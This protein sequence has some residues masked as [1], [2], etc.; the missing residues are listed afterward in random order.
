MASQVI[1]PDSSWLLLNSSNLCKCSICYLQVMF[2]H[3]SLHLLPLVPVTPSP[4]LVLLQGTGMGSPAG[5]WVEAV[6]VTCYMI[7]WVAHLHVDLE[8]LSQLQL[9]L[10]LG[11][12][13]LPLHQ[14]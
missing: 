5:E 8:M 4:S 10:G 2:L 12:M 6:L 3:N 13:V 11:Q 14:H 9:G 7:Q 1:V